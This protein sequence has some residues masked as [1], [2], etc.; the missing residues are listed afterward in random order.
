MFFSKLA[1]QKS[2]LGVDIGTSYI[3]IAQVTHGGQTPVLDTYG[4]V[5][6][7]G[8]V[9]P[10]NKEKA[11][12][13]TA[14]IVH[15]LAIKAKVTAQKCVASLPNSA[16][17]TSVIDMPIMNDDELA[18]AMPFEAKKYVPLPVNEVALSWSIVT[19][20]EE[21]KTQKIL[22]IAVP[23]AVRESYIQLFSLAQLELEII[24]I[25]ALALI[26]SLVA[27]GEANSIIVDMGAKSTGLNVIKDGLLQL[28]RNLNVGGDTIT[29]RIATSLNINRGRAEQFKKDFG[30]SKSSFVPESVKPVLSVI[31]NEVLQLITLYRS[32]NT[33][34][35]RIILVGGS[36]ALPGITTFFSD[37]GPEVSIG[38]P[39]SGLSYPQAIQPVIS[40][41][42][43]QLPIAIGL[44][45]RDESA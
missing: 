36:A 10:V 22:L 40:R 21:T 1:K 38:N 17:F 5:D 2:V 45:L 9:D 16:V 27:A 4:I 24:E 28:T 34:I 35:Q 3:K 19:K 11:V 26:R 6:M 33:P 13:Q 37:L 8:Q 7:T 23:I 29:E 42:S 43:Y 20:N 14:A 39:T 18:S 15:D 30:M 41:Y 32:H 25:E 44:A 31:K 12:A